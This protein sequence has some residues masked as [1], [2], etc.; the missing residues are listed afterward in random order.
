MDG[1][2]SGKPDR[3]KVGRAADQRA[4]NADWSAA[5]EDQTASDQDQTGSD[6]DQVSAEL[7]AASAASDQ[8]AADEDQASADRRRAGVDA[9]AGA[10]TTYEATRLARKT[11][12]AGRLAAQAGRTGTAHLRIGT[13]AG[14]D[15]TATKRDDT[16]RR[17]DRRAEAIERAIAASDA[18]LAEKL[19]QLRARAAV[20]RA[21]AAEDRADAAG[22]RADAARER[23]HLEAE[24][25]GAHLGDLVG[26]YRRETGRLALKLEI[27]RAR[28][29]DGRFV[30]AS[31]DVDGLKFVNDRDG[32]AAGDHVLQ[33]LVRIMASKLRSYDP[34]VRYGGDEFLCG[35]SGSRLGEG[36]RRFAEIDALLQGEVGVGISV[37]LAELAADETLDGLTARADAGLLDAK[38]RRGIQGGD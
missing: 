17:R 38:T 26:A 25:H 3:M 14:R 34:I 22:E 5:D 8:R 31:V 13:A 24:L 12:T 18:P 6:Q 20:D 11:T 21:K 30:L 27:D 16:A 19:E 28:R 32:H 1:N 23:A 7:D 9:D 35:L 4:L 15:A 29:A 10:L 37:G 2:G 36:E 33:A